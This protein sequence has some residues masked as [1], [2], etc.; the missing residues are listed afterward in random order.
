M[1]TA[2]IYDNMAS[3]N[4]SIRYFNLLLVINKTWNLIL[5]QFISF[6]ETAEKNKNLLSSSLSLVSTFTTIVIIGWG[7]M[8]AVDGQI[9]VGALIGANILAARAIMPSVKFIQTLEPIKKAETSLKEVEAILK[10][11]SEL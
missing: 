6:R 7:A 5:N 10:F 9:S 1:N 3:R 8:L 11:P 2:R 4:T